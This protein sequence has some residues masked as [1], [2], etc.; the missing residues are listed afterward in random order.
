MYNMSDSIEY[1]SDNLINI[2]IMIMILIF[3]L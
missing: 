2:M 1:L 3:F